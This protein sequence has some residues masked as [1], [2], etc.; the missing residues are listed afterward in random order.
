MC[1]PIMINMSICG[2]SLQIIK[3]R[4]IAVAASFMYSDDQLKATA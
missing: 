3:R 4:R 2:T 1:L